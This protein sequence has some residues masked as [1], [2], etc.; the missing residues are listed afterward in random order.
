M[1][2]FE[3][4]LKIVVMEIL[5]RTEENNHKVKIG[6]QIVEQANNFNILE[7]L[8][9]KLGKTYAEINE[10]IREENVQSQRNILF[11]N[12]EISKQIR[13]EVVGGDR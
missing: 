2:I 6:K 7:K 1:N 10:R 11:R 12:K 8:Q 9:K 4:H 13:R 5:K 3:V